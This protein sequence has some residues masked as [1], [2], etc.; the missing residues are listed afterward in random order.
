VTAKVVNTVAG[1]FH[2]RLQAHC[3]NDELVDSLVKLHKPDFSTDVPLC[4]GC[5]VGPGT[6]LAPEWPCTTYLIIAMEMLEFEAVR[7]LLLGLPFP[8]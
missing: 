5:D 6:D 1:D 8:G 2:D 4:H 3:G 7:K